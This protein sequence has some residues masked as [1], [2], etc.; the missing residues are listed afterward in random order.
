[1]LTKI[2][3]LI[4]PLLTHQIIG[5]DISLFNIISSI[6]SFIVMFLV[7]RF[8]KVGLSP[9]SLLIVLIFTNIVA[10]GSSLILSPMLALL[11][12][13]IGFVLAI[14]KFDKSCSFGKAA[15]VV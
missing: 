3:H 10:L 2:I 13:F 7:C 12:T 8:L 15:G 14:K 5:N 4:T 6:V 1:M 11:V 9:L